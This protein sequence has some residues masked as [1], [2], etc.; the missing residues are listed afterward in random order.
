MVG[1]RYQG[2]TGEKIEARGQ[3]WDMAG[4]VGLVAWAVLVSFYFLWELS[5]FR[6]IFALACEAQDAA[7][8]RSFPVATVLV[9]V[10]LFASP[11]FL[12]L[13]RPSTDTEAAIPQQAALASANRFART[14]TGAAIIFGAA[15]I[16]LILYAVV[17]GFGGN[18]SPDGRI[19]DASS[20]TAENGPGTVRGD[21]RFSI[22]A[23]YSVDTLFSRQE[24]RIVPIMPAG[25]RSKHLRYFAE[26]APGDVSDTARDQPNGQR[27]GRIIAGSV[28]A[29]VLAMYRKGGY[30]IASPAYLVGRSH[31]IGAAPFWSLAFVMIVGMVVALVLRRVQRAHIRKLPETITP[32][33]VPAT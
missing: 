26:Y 13:R 22:G 6:G 2:E 29:P 23:T 18:A 14:L 9:L 8:G 16:A 20:E 24:V 7:F 4:R 10:L 27:A 12:L 11:A 31:S 28:P 3:I 19:I 5:G 1:S 32:E 25:D 30:E 15:A 33:I 17:L 21:V